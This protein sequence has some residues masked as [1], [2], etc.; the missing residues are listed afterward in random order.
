MLHDI[1]STAA[2]L[3]TPVPCQH[4]KSPHKPHIFKEKKIVK[5]DTEGTP[6]T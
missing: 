5:F 2:H 6:I 1:T 3:N 4:H